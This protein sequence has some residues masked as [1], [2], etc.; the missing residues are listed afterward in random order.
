MTLC[1]LLILGTRFAAAAGTVGWMTPVVRARGA[2][3]A[4]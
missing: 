3:D 1:V 4:C 2:E